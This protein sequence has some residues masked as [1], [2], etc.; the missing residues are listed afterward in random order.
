LFD[1]G[2]DNG[3][4]SYLETGANHRAVILITVDGFTG[5]Q[6]GTFNLVQRLF[7]KYSCNQFLS[8]NCE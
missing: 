4:L 5:E 6:A 7:L 1:D 8:G 2:S 3:F